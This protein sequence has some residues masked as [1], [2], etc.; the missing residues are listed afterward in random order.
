MLPAL[1]FV[2]LHLVLTQGRCIN[3]PIL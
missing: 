2:L 1:L 3:V